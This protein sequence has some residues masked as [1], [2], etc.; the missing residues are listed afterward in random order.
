MDHLPI[1]SNP[2]WSPISVSCDI[3]ACYDGLPFST[4]PERSGWD[5]YRLFCGDFSE[6]GEAET[7]SFLQTWL[8]FGM[9]SNFFGSRFVLNDFT[10]LDGSR[11]LIMTTN[12]LQ[13]V[14]SLKSVQ[15]DWPEGNRQ[16]WVKEVEECFRETKHMIEIFGQRPCPLP[17]E[18]LLSIMVLG[19]TLT[20]VYRWVAYTSNA[21]RF[22]IAES[23]PITS[24]GTSFLVVKRMF[25][26]GWCPSEIARLHS[27]FDVIGMYY[28]SFFER[29]NNDRNH[30]ACSR[31][32]CVEDRIK[33]ATYKTK[34]ADCEGCFFEGPNLSEMIRILENGAYPLILLNESE[35]G[36]KIE[37][38]VVSSSLALPYTA[39]SHVWSHGLGNHHYNELPTCQLRRFDLRLSDLN[40]STMTAP[41]RTHLDIDSQ[42]APRLLWIDT[43]CI[44]L[45]QPYREMAMSR[46]SQV[47]ENAH[48]VIVLDRTLEMASV[49]MTRGELGIRVISSRWMQ[50]LWTLAEGCRARNLHF[51]LHDGTVS[52]D[53][54]KPPLETSWSQIFHLHLNIKS[55]QAL[56][57]FRRL[58]NVA[59][60]EKFDL[61][62]TAIAYR[63]T[64]LL[65]DEPFI[66]GNVI[67]LSQEQCLQIHKAEGQSRML[68]LLSYWQKIPSRILFVSGP[69]LTARGY[70]WAVQ[71]FLARSDLKYLDYTTDG[72]ALPSG[73]LG[74]HTP[75]GLL[76]KYPGFL[77]SI[78]ESDLGGRFRFLDV[79]NGFSYRVEEDPSSKSPSDQPRPAL[80]NSTNQL[81]GIIL[82]H[83]PLITPDR[84]QYAALVIITCERD[85]I[86]HCSWERRIWISSSPIA[87]PETERDPAHAHAA[88]SSTTLVEFT[89]GEPTQHQQRLEQLSA[90]VSVQV[91][92]P[93]QAWCVA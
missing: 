3:D 65:E 11:K 12:L 38:R 90:A 34:H 66:L 26:A 18:V 61:L 62:W 39:I 22:S 43:L 46:I 88:F 17:Q 76:V 53:D 69:R 20:Y 83:L 81:T 30:A 93:E 73:K 32:G 84:G 52:L 13:Y 77:F 7:A 5:K 24:W 6:H 80:S 10:R 70:R 64:S 21:E 58:L 56:M 50:R 86:I 85:G 78:N 45:L 41:D 60:V 19:S 74:N 57:V 82:P 4:Y 28:T 27:N 72:R 16:R 37:T 31:S 55:F 51:Q 35:H 68:L 40:A 49:K 14:K 36:A 47:Y 75:E 15:A 33:A 59:W 91:V 42:E 2:R 29:P 9:L 79:K 92:K 71:S 23:S 8:Y 63:S 54:L 87:S 89:A 25:E 48:A 1:P 67:G 44:P